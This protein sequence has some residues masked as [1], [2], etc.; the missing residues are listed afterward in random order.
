MS[1]IRT[2]SHR[3]PRATAVVKVVLVLGFVVALLSASVE[4]S[5]VDINSPQDT[6]FLEYYSA[7]RLITGGENPY[8]PVRLLA[9]Q[10][11]LGANRDTPLMMWNPPWTLILLDPLLRL[12]LPIS[13]KIWMVLNLTLVLASVYL[14]FQSC[15][16]R[17]RGAAAGLLVTGFSFFPI[18]NAVALGQVSVVLTFAVCVLLWAL[19]EG[20]YG[21]AGLALAILSIKPHLTFLLAVAVFCWAL[22]TRCFRLMIWWGAL[23]LLL[24]VAA[25]VRLPGSINFWINA[26]SAGD[27]GTHVA[28]SQWRVATG[29]GGLVMML[30][31]LLGSKPVWLMR[32]VPLFSSTMLAFWL[33]LRRPAIRWD[34]ALP[35]LVMLSVVLSPFGWVF[36]HSVMLVAPL[37][38]AA[39]GLDSRVKL[40][41]SL[42]IL[43]LVIGLSGVTLLLRITCLNQHHHFFWFPLA[44]LAVWFAARRVLG[45]ARK[46]ASPSIP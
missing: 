23:L 7:Y 19:T 24:V 13:A 26:F 44:L 14:V 28:V 35:I 12:P 11:E 46:V 32:A 43:T 38:I 18:W 6:D 27:D 15:D 16:R 1:L 8:D 20:R 10:Q 40:K 4:L 22:Y 29:T 34:S 36:D 41:Q 45:P 5:A 17:S 33:L 39:W 2:D 25:E 21:Y 30:E 31:L 37:F 9:V 3:G 42:L